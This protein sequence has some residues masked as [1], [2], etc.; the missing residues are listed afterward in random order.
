MD[1]CKVKDARLLKLT[2][3]EKKERRKEYKRK[4]MADKRSKESDTERTD[5]LS[6]NR[7]ARQLESRESGKRRRY[8]NNLCRKSRLNSMSTEELEQYREDQRTKIA[9]I[10]Q[11][12]TQ[13]QKAARQRKDAETRGMGGKNGSIRYVINQQRWNHDKARK[14]RLLP[15]KSE[16]STYTGSQPFLDYLIRHKCMC[17]HPDFVRLMK[18]IIN[19]ASDRELKFIHL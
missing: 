16:S 15:Q 5:R 13:D 2:D 12:Y 3:E 17:F 8:N 4:W 9:K 6:K 19:A 11:N 7:L 1:K 14:Y 10:Q 18:D